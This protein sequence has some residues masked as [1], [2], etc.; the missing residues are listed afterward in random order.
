LR[1]YDD[2]V[3]LRATLRDT[4]HVAIIGAGLIGCEVASTARELGVR[5]TLIDLDRGPFLRVLGEDFSAAIADLQRQ[6][7]VEQMFGAGVSEVSDST[8]GEFNVVLGSGDTVVAGA[9][10]VGTGVTPCVSWLVG[11]GVALANGV[12]CND[13]LRTSAPDV[14]AAGDVASW[15]GGPTGRVVRLEHW[16]NAVEQGA[17]AALSMMSVDPEGVAWIAPVPHFTT[18]LHGHRISVMGHTHGVAREETETMMITEAG[19]TRLAALYREYDQLVGCATIDRPKLAIQLR[20]LMGTADS[21]ERA[22]R[23]AMESRTAA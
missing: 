8:D 19:S 5:T 20:A 2:A 16:A 1:S 12:V 23:L 13:H 18:V 11:S 7:G 15:P 3:R 6:A 14:F 4:N 17:A 21:W 10:V 22:V 9:V